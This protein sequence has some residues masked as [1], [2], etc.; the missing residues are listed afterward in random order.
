MQLKLLSYKAANFC[1]VTC[2]TGKVY[3]ESLSQTVEE[4]PV[5][6]CRRVVHKEVIDQLVTVVPL[7]NVRSILVELVGE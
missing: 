6:N 1:F 2:Q 7:Q 4:E 3:S 5:A